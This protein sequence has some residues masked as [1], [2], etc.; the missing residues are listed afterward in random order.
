MNLRSVELKS[1][2]ASAPNEQI[3]QMP[4]TAEV[5][6]PGYGWIFVLVDGIASEGR[7]IMIGSGQL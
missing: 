1:Y 7:W 6:P 2:P 4:V 3:V 5:Y